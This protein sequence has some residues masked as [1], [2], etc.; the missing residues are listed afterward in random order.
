ML[1]SQETSCAQMFGKLP[2]S[3]QGSILCSKGVL[4][5]AGPQQELLMSEGMGTP[6]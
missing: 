5:E 2:G 3:I 6:S 1:L 4:C